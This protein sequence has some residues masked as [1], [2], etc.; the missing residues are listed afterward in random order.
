MCD[1]GYTAHIYRALVLKPTI[2]ELQIGNDMFFGSCYENTLL[3]G[4]KAWTTNHPSLARRFV[5]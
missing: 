1:H 3:H 4:R 5:T 2:K